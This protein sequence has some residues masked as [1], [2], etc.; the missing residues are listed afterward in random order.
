MVKIRRGDLPPVIL[1]VDTSI[2]FHQNKK[3]PVNPEF[4]KFWDEHASE[5]KVKLVVPEV[6]RGELLC[7]QT[8]AA[9]QK[10]DNVSSSMEE[11]SSIA[12]KEYTHRLS[13]ARIKTQIIKKLEKWIRGKQGTI[14]KT[15]I[16]TID[17]K[18]L[19]DRALW[20]KPP[21]SYDGKKKAEKGFKDSLVLET[22]VDLTKKNRGNV[23]IAFV[24]GDNLLRSSSEA[25]LKDDKRCLFFESLS[26]VASYLKLTRDELTQEFARSLLSRASA[27]FFTKGDDSSLYYREKIKDKLT[28]EHRDKLT[29]PES[30]EE[31]QYGVVLGHD[32]LSYTWTRSGQA[33]WYIQHPQYDKHEGS[34]KYYWDSRITYVSLRSRRRGLLAPTLPPEQPRLLK[35]TFNVKWFA[36][37][38]SDGRFHDM[39]VESMELIESSFRTPTDEDRKKYELKEDTTQHPTT[40]PWTLPSWE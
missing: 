6:V 34:K 15:P 29:T 7:Q 14:A 16:S 17:W 31:R 4:D 23:Q 32:L 27:K 9:L 37:V 19:I 10:I 3:H 1:V 26:D 33:T 12:A 36:N 40:M 21:F 24:T 30:A 18:Q 25:R 22:L 38:K 2:L 35:L 8:S 5:F 20:K 13:P 11:I 28:E 39:A